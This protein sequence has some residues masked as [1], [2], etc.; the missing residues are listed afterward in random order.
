MSPPAAP[1][2][3]VLVPVY[4]EAP[5]L[6]RL[7]ASFRALRGELEAYR[8]AFHLVDDGSTDGTPGEGRRLGEGLDLEVL[9]HPSNQGPGRAFATAF[10]RLAPVIGDEDWVVT[11][12]GDNTSRVEILRQM[13]RRTEEGYDAVLASPYMYG[14][15]I[16]HTSPGRV[17]LSH[18]ANLV[19]KEVLGIHG[20]LTMSS[21]YR[22]YR[23]SLLKRLQR[24]YGPGIVERA[25]FESMVELLMKMIF[26]ETRLSEVPMALDTARRAGKSKMK[27]ARTILGYLTLWKDKGRWRAQAAPPGRA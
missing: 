7:M 19:V 9:V 20:I 26:L 24:V 18:A 27:V 12:E 2:L 13:L 16:A 14:G 10:A 22:L 5:N 3:H 4:N 8:V 17:F 23:G 21:F 25:G 6:E 15:G 1:R 11:M